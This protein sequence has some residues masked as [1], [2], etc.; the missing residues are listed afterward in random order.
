MS[1]KDIFID[2]NITKNF[3]NPLDPAYKTLI[4][5]LIRF[6][7]QDKRQNAYLVVSNKLLAEYFRTSGHAH[8]ST[9]ITV[10]INKL[11]R[12]GRLIKISNQ[13]IKEFKRKYFTKKVSKKL[14]C[15]QEDQEHIPVVLL[16]DRKY[17]LSLDKKFCDDL[18]NFPGFIVTAKRRPQDLPYDE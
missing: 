3:A 13:Q 15:N 10:I 12:E 6:N 18:I 16:S 7:E 4:T 8:S 5:W 1:K 2:N 11:Q 17:V 14:T 9:N